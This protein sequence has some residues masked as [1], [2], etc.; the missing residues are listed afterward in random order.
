[1]VNYL[2]ANF[3][4]VFGEDWKIRWNT[5]A[6]AELRRLGFNTVGNWSDWK[7]A[8]IARF[9]YVRPLDFEAATAPVVYRD[10]PDVFDPRFEQDAARAAQQLAATKTDPALIGYFLMN[11]PTWGFA[12]ETPA[13]GMAIRGRN[14]QA[15]EHP[16]RWRRCRSRETT[17][18]GP[19]GQRR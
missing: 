6:M 16:I 9:P 15:R 5:I 17:H 3:I 18:V 1:M 11:E 7:V 19:G 8:S 14:D 10:F 12:S 2:T 4:R 13:A